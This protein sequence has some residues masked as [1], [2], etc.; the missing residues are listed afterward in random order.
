M[1]NCLFNLTRALAL[2]ALLSCAT[3]QAESDVVIGVSAG[4]GVKG[5]L[6]PLAIEKGIKTAIEEINA[7]GGVL[8]GR[9]LALATNDDRGVPARAIDALKDFAGNPDV[10]AVF[11]GLYSPVAL[12][13]V[14]FANRERILLLDPWAAADGIANNGAQ[15]NYVFRLSL[16]DTLALRTMA[17]NALE[18]KLHRIAL[19]LPNTGWGR[20]SHAAFLA[21]ARNHPEMTSQSFWYSWG[22]TD[23]TPK[24]LEAQAWGAQAILM[25]ANDAEGSKIVQQLAKLPSDKRPPIIAHWGITGGDFAASAGPALQSVDLVVVQTFTFADA[26]GEAAARART[27]YRNLF[28]ADIGTLRAQV[29]FAHA[30]DLTYLLAQA[31]QKAGSTDRTAIRN[32][33]E[34]LATHAG[35]VRHYIRPFTRTQHEA[36]EE[37]Q[38]FLARFRKD[39]GLY[40]DR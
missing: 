29:G 9:R 15:P 22:D 25:V 24:L 12:E 5:N 35:L 14:P 3:A 21:Y 20:S 8:G 19:F 18:R 7:A 17:R 26:K 11:C 39:G 13:L 30:Y 37:K 16:T 1:T 23:F 27:T 40:K 2:L 36:L 33:M 6:A 10:V 34:Q 32:A 4:Y 28:D 38:V 31:V